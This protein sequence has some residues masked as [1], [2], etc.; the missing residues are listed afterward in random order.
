MVIIDVINTYVA[1]Y[2]ILIPVQ[3]LAIILVPVGQ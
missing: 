3:D 2:F 1:N